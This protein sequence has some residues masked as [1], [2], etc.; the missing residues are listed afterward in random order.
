VSL[1][2]L[3][4]LKIAAESSFALDAYGRMLRQKDPGGSPAPLFL[5]V[6]CA[7]GNIAYFHRDVSAEIAGTIEDLV[8]S[9]PPLCTRDSEPVQ[10][11]RYRALLAQD[12]P[13]SEPEIAFAYDLPNGTPFFSDVRIVRSGTTDGD[14]LLSDYARSGVLLGLQEMGFKD[15]GEFW[16][17]WCV[18][19]EDG[20]AAAIAFAARLGAR[21]A[22]TGV[23][24]AKAF[25]G[26]GLAAAAVAAWSAHPDLKNK[27]LGYSHN[28]QNV[29]SQRVT[30]RLGLR[31]IGIQ[32]RIG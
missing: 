15:K 3:D 17:P 1:T 14:A 7:A 29:S 5:L 20:Q 31:F 6:G 32:L 25:R 27:T 12:A 8:R 11:E 4:R 22:A 2:D 16:A 18:A 28:R 10:L 30:E 13:A 9:E 23:A 26:R 21:G 24:T 19:F